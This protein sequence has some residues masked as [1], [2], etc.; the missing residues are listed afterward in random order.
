MPHSTIWKSVFLS[1]AAIPLFAATLVQ[2]Q[3]DLTVHEWGTFT[4][5]AG[6]NGSSLSWAPLSVASDLPCFVHTRANGLVKYQMGLVRMETPVVYFYT[7][8]ETKA[9]VLVGSPQDEMSEWYPKAQVTPNAGLKGG[10]SIE[11]AGL[12]ILPGSNPAL[13]STAGRSRYYAARATDAAP[14]QAGN[15][16]EK[17]LF[18]R[19]IANFKAPRLFQSPSCSKTTTAKSAIA[20]FAI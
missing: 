14:V 7:R 19:G 17:L 12:K 15:E 20:S 11:W 18:Y 8:Q 5:V 2:N 10:G 4:S 13:P 6:Y 3:N 1:A 16:N 9:S